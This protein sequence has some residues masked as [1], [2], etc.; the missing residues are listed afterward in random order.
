MKTLKEYILQESLL[1]NLDDLLD[2]STIEVNTYNKLG[3]HYY[4]MGISDETSLMAFFGDY[5]KILNAFDEEKLK[6]I[7]KSSYQFDLKSKH[8]E[9]FKFKTARKVTNNKIKLICN[10]ILNMEWGW[11]K[12][13]NNF[14]SNKNQ[15]PLVDYFSNLV[16]DEFIN[17]LKFFKNP[18]PSGAFTLSIYIDKDFDDYIE[19]NFNKK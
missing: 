7:N 17:D 9:N 16:K 8:G 5:K 4:P 2:K 18:L 14:D 11:I 15:T 6:K 19:I 3:K 10:A 12:D 13:F 1:D